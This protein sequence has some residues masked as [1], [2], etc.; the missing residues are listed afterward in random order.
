MGCVKL[1]ILDKQYKKTEL[2]VSNINKELTL[3]FCAENTRRVVRF[4]EVFVEE[5][6]NK[7]NTPYLFNA[8]ELDEE[9]GLYYY[10]ARYYDP[11]VSV[12]LGVDPMWEK[13]QGKSVYTF[14][15]DNPVKYL[16]ANGESLYILFHV[17]G[18]HHD[19]GMFEAAALTR[20]KDIEGSSSFNSKQD[21][22][23]VLA[24]QDISKIGEM[25]RTTVQENEAVYG[26]TAEFDI[27]AHTG[28]VNGPVGSVKTSQNDIDGYQMTDKGWS[29]I[30]FNWAS[31]AQASFYGCRTGI[32]INGDNQDVPKGR[33]SFA[34]EMSALPNFKDVKVTGL[35]GSG[36]A[37]I[38]T[39][40]RDNI[41]RGDNDF[42]LGK[43]PDGKTI[44]SRTYIVG[45]IRLRNN[46]YIPS[47]TAL[48][49]ST[50]I[51]GK[52]VV[53]GYQQGVQKPNK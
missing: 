23:V 53:G 49:I 22:I 4:G 47:T 26:K 42:M 8:K 7:W 48:P 16:D 25:I 44:F 19:D 1:H 5:R 15:M 39:N 34:T 37:S 36:F 43:T 45:G 10:G 27:W 12:W 18:Y 14:C 21:K 41:G 46:F 13:Y 17:T 9:T 52:G 38:Y 20:K 40:Y 50:S 3:N 51:N 32:I 29:E 6:N 31:N 33:A 24:V 28:P 11:R 35:T 30:N 2:K